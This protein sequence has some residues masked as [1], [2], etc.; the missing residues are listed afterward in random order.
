[1]QAT[2]RPDGPN[3]LTDATVCLLIL[4]MLHLCRHKS[5]RFSWL[6]IFVVALSVFVAA[7]ATCAGAC[8]V[9]A[10]PYPTA[11]ELPPVS[12][13]AG[14]GC[15]GE[16]G[17]CGEAPS[18]EAPFETSETE[19]N[20]ISALPSPG[21][22]ARISVSVAFFD[23]PVLLLP[24]YLQVSE[25]SPRLERPSLS[26]ASSYRSFVFRRDRSRAPPHIA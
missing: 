12:L 18:A 19:K 15:C 22:D 4:Y 5:R 24:A 3:G 13:D 6:A 8:R 7:P 17:C 23:M 14:E 11:A 21:D 10:P 2:T 1:M 20:C 26:Q 25:L 9:A 16:G